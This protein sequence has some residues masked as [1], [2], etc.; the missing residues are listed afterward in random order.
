MKRMG[1]RRCSLRPLFGRELSWS[2]GQMRAA[3][4]AQRGFPNTADLPRGDTG[5]K[6]GRGAGSGGALLGFLVTQ[7]Q[8]RAG[9]RSAR[10]RGQA[11]D[12]ALRQLATGV[13][14]MQRSFRVP[15]WLCCQDRKATCP[16]RY[17]PPRELPDPKVELR[18]SPCNGTGGGGER[19]G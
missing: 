14:D 6:M 8:L 16:E 12:G 5:K 3:A 15:H 9:R 1:G 19:A 11:R 13:A 4:R 18:G 10:S 2:S 7:D 17:G